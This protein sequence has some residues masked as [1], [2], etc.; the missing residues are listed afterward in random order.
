MHD[1]N[2]VHNNEESRRGGLDKVFGMLLSTRD[3]EKT[4]SELL[5][6]P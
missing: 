2:T 6:S 5:S 3:S 4:H 1:Y